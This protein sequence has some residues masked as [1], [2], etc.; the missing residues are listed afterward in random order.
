LAGNLLKT[1]FIIIIF[2]KFSQRKYLTKETMNQKENK[3]GLTTTE[4]GAVWNIKVGV[5]VPAEET[6]QSGKQKTKLW[7]IK[8]I[9]N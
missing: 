9:L 4:K 8:V 6:S 1:Y 2:G 3:S 5:W 7:E